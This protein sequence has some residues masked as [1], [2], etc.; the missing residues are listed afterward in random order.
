VTRQ[1]VI[2]AAKQLQRRFGSYYSKMNK[3]EKE[4]LI[5]DLLHS[6]YISDDLFLAGFEQALPGWRY[7]PSMAEIA[8]GVGL[9]AEK[10]WLMWRSYFA[11]PDKTMV[12]RGVGAEFF[13]RVHSALDFYRPNEVFGL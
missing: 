5:D 11:F 7:P 3:A 10:M 1:A 13:P 2:E 8:Q 12:Y 4:Q 9:Y 6:V